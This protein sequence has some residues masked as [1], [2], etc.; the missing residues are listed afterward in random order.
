LLVNAVRRDES[1][2]EI[3]MSD[4]KKENRKSR[5]RGQVK[6]PQPKPAQNSEPDGRIG[7]GADRDTQVDQR[8]KPNPDDG[9][10]GGDISR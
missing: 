6:R 7:E 9:M 8:Q 5:Q 10:L 3:K 2:G 1:Y 4:P